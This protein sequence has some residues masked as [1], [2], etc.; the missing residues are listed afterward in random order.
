MP[1]PPAGPHQSVVPLRQ[2]PQNDPARADRT[3]SYRG[4]TRCVRA[5]W[6]AAEAGKRGRKICA[7]YMS[8]SVACKLG[9]ACP[10]YHHD[11][12]PPDAGGGTSS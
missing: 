8:N 10:F 4:Y 12:P 3:R 9:R 6:L 5:D 1:P 11:M 7:D 2:P